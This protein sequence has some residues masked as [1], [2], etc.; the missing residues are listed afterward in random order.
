MQDE[1]PQTEYLCLSHNPFIDVIAVGTDTGTIKLYDEK[2]SKA[3]KPI[4][5]VLVSFEC[6]NF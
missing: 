5:M 3:N 2:T 6:L 1:E 4:I